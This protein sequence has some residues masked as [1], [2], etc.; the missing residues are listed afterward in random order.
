VSVLSDRLLLM[1][2][3]QP[4]VS[5]MHVALG[6]GSGSVDARKLIVDAFDRLTDQDSNQENRKRKKMRTDAIA[7]CSPKIS[8]V[9]EAG[10]SVWSAD[11]DASKEF[12]NIA[13]ASLGAVSI[14]RRLQDPLGEFVKIPPSA[15][16]L[17]M[18]QHDLCPKELESALR[19][20]TV[21]CVAI[22]GVDVNTASQKLL[23]MV[24]LFSYIYLLLSFIF[25]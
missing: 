13:A 18:Y 19:D 11:S 24:T 2:K 25:V 17:G 7:R 10:A 9:R 3:E 8:V 5:S 21:D 4:Q 12:P 6:D 1:Q 22:V 14:G 15:L 16:G 23:S 20:V